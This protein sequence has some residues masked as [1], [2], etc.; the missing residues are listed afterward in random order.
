MVVAKTVAVV[1]T[2]E[3]MVPDLA[4]VT[5]LQRSQYTYTQSNNL[6]YIRS[7]CRGRDRLRLRRSGR[8]PDVSKIWT[9]WRTLAQG[10]FLGL[11]ARCNALAM[12][13]S[14]QVG[15]RAA[16]ELTSTPNIAVA[17]NG[18]NDALQVARSGCALAVGEVDTAGSVVAGL[19]AL[20]EIVR[21]W[22]AAGNLKLHQYCGHGGMRG[23]SLRSPP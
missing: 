9:I 8:A 23:C 17:A 18:E 10:F 13:T 1:E 16:A 11:A 12:Q 20:V 5:V 22:R 19:Y 15:L 14:E 3:V 6:K 7:R 4:G 2:V 21:V